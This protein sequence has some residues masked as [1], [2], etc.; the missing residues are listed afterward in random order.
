MVYEWSPPDD[1]LLCFSCTWSLI[2][3]PSTAAAHPELLDEAIVLKPHDN[4]RVWTDDFSNMFR[5][6]K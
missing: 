5:I 3:D 6:L 4:F 2:M 1:D